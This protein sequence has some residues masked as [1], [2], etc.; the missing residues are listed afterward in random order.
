MIMF[1][2]ALSSQI[3]YIL[4]ILLTMI[5]DYDLVKIKN[6]DY[7]YVVY[8]FAGALI[9]S[10]VVCVLVTTLAVKMAKKKPSKMIKGILFFWVFIF[11][12]VPINLICMVKKETV[13]HQIDHTVAVNLDQVT[14]ENK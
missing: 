9:L 2:M 13:W 11:S 3:L 10:Y 14:T 5:L 7:M 4:S 6:I 1:L 8:R 12:W